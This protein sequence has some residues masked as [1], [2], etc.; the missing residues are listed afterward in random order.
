MKYLKQFEELNPETYIS[1]G[2]KLKKKFQTV[3]G[4]NLIGYG[5]NLKNNQQIISDTNIYK[6]NIMTTV[7]GKLP[8]VLQQ[9]K[10]IDYQI[11]YLYHAKDPSVED[12]IN[13]INEIGYRISFIFENEKGDFISPFAFDVFLYSSTNNYRTG[14][15]NNPRKLLNY[16]QIRSSAV[17]MPSDKEVYMQ[18]LFADRRSAV[19]FVKNILSTIPNDSDFNASEIVSLIKR[20]NGDLEE[21]YNVF[22]KIDINYLYGDNISLLYKEQTITGKEKVE[23]VKSRRLPPPRFPTS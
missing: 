10:F 12:V 19:L 2:D 21:I 4:H 3:R 7:D 17:K 1:A 20:P 15:I 14:T 5:T 6:Y 16:I 18:G 23:K 22:N 8:G 13:N 11:K 9:C